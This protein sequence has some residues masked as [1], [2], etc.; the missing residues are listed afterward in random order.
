MKTR[1]IKTKTK[2][3][4]AVHSIDEILNL[5]HVI[6]EE[7]KEAHRNEE[8]KLVKTV[9]DKSNLLHELNENL[10]ELSRDGKL[11]LSFQVLS[12][13]AKVV[14]ELVLVDKLRGLTPL[15]QMKMRLFISMKV[16]GNYQLRRYA[17]LTELWDEVI[18]REKRVLEF[19]ESKDRNLYNEAIREV[20]VNDTKPESKP[21]KKRG[22]PKREDKPVSVES[23]EVETVIA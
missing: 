13:I 22:R 15:A 11:P 18:Q 6:T 7:Q 16:M 8:I 17:R 4:P 21:Q 5:E 12:E 3:V 10:S 20:F 23:D 2:Q 9:M 14:N 19:I 1:R